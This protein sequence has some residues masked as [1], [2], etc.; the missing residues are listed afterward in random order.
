VSAAASAPVVYPTPVFDHLLHLTDRHGTFEH[1]RYGE[2]RPEHGYCTDDMARVLVVAAREGGADP[3]LLRLEALSLRFLRA[4]QGVDGDYRNRMDH[5][6]RWSGRRTVDDCWGRSIWALGTAVRHSRRDWVR[7]T[8]AIQFE[9]SASLRSPSPRAMAFASIGGA[10]VLA[11]VPGDRVARSLVEAAAAT[12]SPPVSDGAWPWPEGRLAYANPVLAEARIAAGVALGRP[13][14]LADGLLLLGWLLDRETRDGHLSVTPHEG[15]GISDTA[16]AFDQQP[17]E[18]AALADACARASTVDD[19]PRWS[20]GVGLAVAWFLG[21]NDN[22][23]AMWDPV[24][25]GGYDGLTADG[26]NLNQGAEST[27]ALLATLQHARHL[28]AVAG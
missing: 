15:A 6:G 14:L 4:A 28:V 21:D 8:A 16:P 3:S 25:G 7:Q 23:L 5:R 9:R 1:A 26:V 12:M 19:D 22:G 24:T 17:I 27:L 18:V 20:A 10:E 13:G 2:P 11:A